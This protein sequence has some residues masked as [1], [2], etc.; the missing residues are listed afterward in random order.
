MIIR[1][2][3]PADS[4]AITN[5]IMLAMG[6]IVYKFIGQD[7]EAEAT[8]FMEGLVRKENNP[9]SYENCW[10]VDIDGDVA[11]AG[12]VYDGADVHTLRKTVAQEVRTIFD[13][14][15]AQ[16]YEASEV[17]TQAGE[18]YID[19]VGVCPSHQGKGIGSKLFQ[20]LMNEYVD[21]RKGVLGLL[22]DKDNPDAK[23]LYLKLG[24][25]IVAEKTL[26]GK[27]MEHLQFGG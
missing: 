4:K 6:E 16:K 18:Y 24:F 14:D 7:A 25:Q 12:V 21:S 22:V 20:F 5:Y 11:A 2:A 1:K 23:K 13:E 8:Q 10:V 9:Y 17:E 15:L 3:V 19:C 27:A 26:T